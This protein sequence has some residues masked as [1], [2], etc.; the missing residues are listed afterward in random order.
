MDAT[1]RSVRAPNKNIRITKW[2]VKPGQHVSQGAI[3]CIYETD[4]AKSL[5]I[6]S[7]F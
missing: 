7:S 6:K 2:K 3:L 1:M 5:K 4:G